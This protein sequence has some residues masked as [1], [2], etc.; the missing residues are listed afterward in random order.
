MEPKKNLTIKDIAKLANVSPGTVDRVIHNRG[1]VSD[2]ALA[3]VSV[4]LEE[5]QYKPN[6]FA[7]S[8]KKQKS[9]SF[10]VLIPRKEDDGYWRTAHEGITRAIEDFDHFGIDVKVTSFNSKLPADFTSK[11]NEILSESPNGL[12]I[13]PIFLQESLDILKKFENAGIPYVTF[14]TKIPDL[15]PSCA[16]GQNLKQS[17]RLAANLIDHCCKQVGNLLIIH[18]DENPGNAPHMIQKEHGFR[19][20]FQSKNHHLE[21][22]SIVIPHREPALI[23]DILNKQA[24]DL[25]NVTGAFVTTAKVHLVAY[26][27]KSRFNDCVVIGYD[28][29]ANNIDGIKS[30]TI[31]FLINQNPYMAAYEGIAKL[32]DLLV[33]GK[34]I[35]PEKLLPLDIITSENLDSYLLN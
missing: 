3:K 32:T 8:L 15:N 33:F 2:K 1:K 30:G 26:P 16:I 6:V 24:G 7:Q 35:D 25:R 21:I 27:I 12:L 4:V 10:S 19:E 22:K 31:D 34:N 17:G 9:L 23:N 18:L 14:N 11:A 5:I 28:P 20:Y 29:T 13:T